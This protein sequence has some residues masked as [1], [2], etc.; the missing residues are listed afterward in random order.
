MPRHRTAVGDLVALADSRHE[1]TYSQ[2]LTMGAQVRR[3]KR[4]TLCAY[5]DQIARDA[6]GGTLVDGGVALS[7]DGAKDR[8]LRRTGLGDFL[9]A[10]PCWDFDVAQIDGLPS[11]LVERCTDAMSPSPCGPIERACA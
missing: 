11:E 4:G 10:R 6:R 8:A 3:G 2:A 5:F 7:D 9:A 1:A